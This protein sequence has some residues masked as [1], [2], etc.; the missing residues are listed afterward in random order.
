[1]IIVA[2]GQVDLI[3]ELRSI[4]GEAVVVIEDRRHDGTLL[5]RGREEAHPVTWPYRGV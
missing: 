3:R 1:M 2:R 4:F 5:P